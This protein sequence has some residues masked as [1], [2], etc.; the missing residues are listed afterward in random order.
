MLRTENGGGVF[1]VATQVVQPLVRSGKASR[2]VQVLDTGEPYVR[3]CQLYGPGGV[4]LGR[5]LCPLRSR[6]HRGNTAQVE[7]TAA[8]GSW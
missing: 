1:E 5:I 7:H 3:W 6:A 4:A 2:R 8:L